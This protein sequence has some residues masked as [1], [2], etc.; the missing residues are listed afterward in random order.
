[1]PV[2]DFD[3]I[4]DDY[5][6]RIRPI[7]QNELLWFR[8]QPTL[9]AAVQLAATAVKSRGK[10]YSHQRRI[11]KDALRRARAVLSANT[12]RVQGCRDF[13]ELIDLLDRLLAPIDGLGELYV[14]D[15]ALRVGAKL[16]IGPD[17]V[18]LHAGTRVGAK[19]LGLDSRLA[20]LEVSLLPLAWH[21]LAPH[22]I[23]D[24][25]CIYKEHLKGGKRIPPER[26][27]S[28]RSWCS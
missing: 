15:T 20:T 18:Y 13:L 8:N 11:K 23:E 4:K 22:E 27:S 7:A 19:A 12:G 5:V 21:G 28:D 10:R 1:M 25:L 2:L 26:S 24:I 16:G 14:Y 6:S 9:E 3:A 17:K